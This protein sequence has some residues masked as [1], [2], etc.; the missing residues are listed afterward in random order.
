MAT[1]DV[2]EPAMRRKQFLAMLLVY[3]GLMLWLGGLVFF[4]FGVAGT[5]F[6]HLS[7]RDLAGDLNGIILG[8]LNAIEFVAALLLAGGLMLYNIKLNVWAKIPIV[9]AGVMLV[10]ALIY[11]VVIR[12]SLDDVKS[13]IGSFDNPSPQELELKAEFDGYH[14]LY[15][16]LVGIN[17]GLGFI[18]FVWQ[19]LIFAFPD[20]FVSGPTQKEIPPVEPVPDGT[21]DSTLL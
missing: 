11:G 2:F 15:S 18:L 7:S 19:T 16:R 17:M 10:I 8:R 21:P 14:K 9:I 20:R 6:K 12:S 3:T 4:G 5:I 1:V 13:R